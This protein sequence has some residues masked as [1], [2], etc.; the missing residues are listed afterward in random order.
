VQVKR[1]VEHLEKL[2]EEHDALYEKYKARPT[3]ARAPK[4]AA[5]TDGR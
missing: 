4:S 5:P 3:A 2:Q 1:R